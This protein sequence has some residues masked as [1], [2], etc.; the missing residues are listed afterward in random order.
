MQIIMDGLLVAAALFA[1]TYCWV[2]SRRVLALKDLDSG[3]G[4]AITQMTRALEDARRALEDAKTA[5]R[6]GRQE[7]RELIT[8]AEAA[9]GQLRILLAASRDLAPEPVARLERAAPPHAPRAHQR[10]PEPPARAP[11]PARAPAPEPE[12]PRAHEPEAD[13]PPAAE[14]RG[15]SGLRAERW[16]AAPQAAPTTADPERRLPAGGRRAEAPSLGFVAAAGVFPAE[17]DADETP[18]RA[19]DA[20]PAIPKPRRVFP[21]ET[22]RPRPQPAI[23]APED[24]TG[25]LAEL[26]ALAGRRS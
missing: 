6:D 9:S 15:T 22:L 14:A 3:L 4:G 5:T 1:G 18:E 23:V 11:Q 19:A 13:G 25:L 12:A 16:S 24:E 10:H 2:L 21:V 7:Q 8:R 17:P 26:A 20:A